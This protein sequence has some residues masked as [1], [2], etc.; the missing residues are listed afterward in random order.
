M[1][2]RRQNQEVVQ[3]ESFNWMY[4]RPVLQS[5]AHFPWKGGPMAKPETTS[6][7]KHQLN[8]RILAWTASPQSSKTLRTASGLRTPTITLHPRATWG[9]FDLMVTRAKLWSYF[10]CITILIILI[11]ILLSSHTSFLTA[12][13]PI[14]RPPPVTTTSFPPCWTRGGRWRWR[15]HT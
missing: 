12:F 5:F 14:P 15:S 3:E 9:H 10:G 2:K 11:M 7:L 13:S 4:P 1:I 8:F 6:F